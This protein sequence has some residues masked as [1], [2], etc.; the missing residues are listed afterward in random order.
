MKL[1]IRKAFLER[2]LLRKGSREFYLPTDLPITITLNCF[3][4]KLSY[5]QTNFYQNSATLSLHKILTQILA[6]K[7]AID[8]KQYA[9]FCHT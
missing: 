9:D 6:T 4:R 7:T 2:L 5:L 3:L 8:S 1:K